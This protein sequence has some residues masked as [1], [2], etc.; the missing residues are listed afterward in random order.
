MFTRIIAWFVYIVVYLLDVTS[1][2]L[3]AS[4]HSV[5]PV[6]YVLVTLHYAHACT[7]YIYVMPF[8]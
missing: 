5:R 1:Q 7:F 2:G 6:I 3:H 4:S 8:V